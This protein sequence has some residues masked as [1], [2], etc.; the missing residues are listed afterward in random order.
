MIP[1]PASFHTDCAVTRNLNREAF[2]IRSKPPQP[3][4]SMVCA[5]MPAPPKIC[6]KTVTTR[7]H[8]KKC[9]RYMIACAT[10]RTRGRI[11]LLISSA[12]AMGIGKNSTSWSRNSTMVFFTAVQNSGS[13]SMR[14]NCSMPTQGLW[15]IAVM[16]LLEEYGS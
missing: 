5:M 7:T 6:W 9:G 1:Q 10:A 13:S 2:V 14:E 3:C 8:E 15:K 16:P 4:C 11:T 12:R